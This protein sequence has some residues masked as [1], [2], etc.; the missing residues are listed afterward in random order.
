MEGYNFTFVELLFLFTLFKLCLKNKQYSKHSW[1]TPA[2]KGMW[3]WKKIL[4]VPDAHGTQRPNAASPCSVSQ[5][6][7]YR[8]FFFVVSQT[9][10][11]K[12]LPKTSLTKTKQT[13]K[14]WQTVFRKWYLIIGEW[15]VGT[16]VILKCIHGPVWGNSCSHPAFLKGRKQYGN[17]HCEHPVLRKIYFTINKPVWHMTQYTFQEIVLF[18]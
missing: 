3:A 12:F 14:D 7:S 6:I 11:A 10:A 17:L 4:L 15:P 8:K 2:S 18:C 1:T 13:N 5:Y 9:C 16:V